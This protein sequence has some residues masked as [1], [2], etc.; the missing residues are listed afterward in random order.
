MKCGEKKGKKW[1]R[2]R[3]K[4]DRGES[5]IILEKG[6]REGGERGREREM[7]R[8][9]KEGDREWKEEKI[10]R[11]AYYDNNSIMSRL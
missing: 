9:E 7:W 10:T 5:K 1:K 3:K 8:K 11:D 2:D 4:R 6:G